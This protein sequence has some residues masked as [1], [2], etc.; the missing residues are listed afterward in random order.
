MFFRI[1]DLFSC[2]I[3]ATEL[4]NV[5]LLGRG[6]NRSSDEDLL[7]IAEEECK[8]VLMIILR[9]DT[10]CYCYIVCYQVTS[11]KLT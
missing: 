10:K 6:G 5:A 8:R 3:E 11:V 1:G 7:T 2:F 9:A 4:Q